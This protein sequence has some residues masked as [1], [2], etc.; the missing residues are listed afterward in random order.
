MEVTDRYLSSAERDALLRMLLGYCPTQPTID[1][2]RRKGQFVDPLKLPGR[3]LWSENDIRR[4]VASKT[5]HNFSE[6]VS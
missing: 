1:R 6:A 2:W 4:W 3:N 5:P